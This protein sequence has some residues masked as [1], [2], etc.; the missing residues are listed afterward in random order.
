LPHPRV[1]EHGVQLVRGAGPVVLEGLFGP[2]KVARLG[3]IP[4]GNG[5]VVSVGAVDQALDRV[6][7]VVDEEAKEKR[8][9]YKPW[10]PPVVTRD[11]SIF[12]HRSQIKWIDR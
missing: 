10:L 4:D 11:V 3:E 1:G 2:K 8:F 9:W 12:G 7:V 6:A 5:V